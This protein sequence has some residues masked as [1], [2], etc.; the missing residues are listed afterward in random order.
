MGFFSDFFSTGGKTEVVADPYKDVREPL[1]GFLNKRIGQPGPTYSGQ[2][3]AGMSD[4]ERASIDFLNQYQ[5]GARG[6]GETGRAAK[7]EIMKTLEGNYDP[8]T[9]PYYQAV[10]AEAERNLSKTKEGIA[11][12]QAGAGGFFSGATQQMMTDADIGVNQYLAAVMGDL[13]EKERQNMLGVI[14]QAYAMD[15]A[16]RNIPLETAMNLQ[17]YGSLPRMLEQAGLDTGY[18]DW[19]LSNIQYP[20]DIANLSAG[21]QTPPTY[22]RT[23]PGMFWQM[24]NTGLEAVGDYFTAGQY[25]KSRGGPKKPERS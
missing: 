17:A 24:A 10:K 22:Q 8:S 7:G 12:R 20:M 15:V 6:L 4:P 3:V 1:V 18:E 11:D 13:A 23:S 2:R 21:V 16:E 5:T 9:S 19:F 25:S 14:P